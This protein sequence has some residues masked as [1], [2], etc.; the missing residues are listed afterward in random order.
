MSDA[1]GNTDAVRLRQDFGARVFNKGPR[2]CLGSSSSPG[3][4]PSLPKALS[5][6]GAPDFLAGVIHHRRA[7]WRRQLP[8]GC[9]PPRVAWESIRFPWAATQ[10]PR[11]GQTVWNPPMLLTRQWRGQ[12]SCVPELIFSAWVLDLAFNYKHCLVECSLL[13]QHVQ[14]SPILPGRRHPSQPGSSVYAV[15]SA[16]VPC[17]SEAGAA[18]DKQL[19]TWPQ[20]P[21]PS[22]SSL[23]CTMSPSR[24]I[25][26]LLC[27][28]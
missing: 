19:W 9:W 8:E 27:G 28:F 7:W 20:P 6:W 25:S 5:D 26:M 4:L 13:L 21:P 2:W 10:L 14:F 1:L 16:H 23:P 18:P 15:E 17:S 11:V 12:G 3:R 24:S 22:G